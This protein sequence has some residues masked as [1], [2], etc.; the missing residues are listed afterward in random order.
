V[1]NIV[2]RRMLM[3]PDAKLTFLGCTDGVTDEKNVPE[4]ARKRAETVRDYLRDTW[5]IADNRL[6]IDYRGMPEKYSNP[7]TQDGILEN[8]RVEVLTDDPDI[9]EPIL[10]TDT[11]RT[12]YVPNVR[13]LPTVKAEAGVASWNVHTENQAKPLKEFKGTTT[14][15][16]N[17]DWELQK[18][19]KNVL[20]T[21][22]S[23]KYELTATDQ[24]SQQASTAPDSV[25]VEQLTIEKKRE[26][27]IADTVF[28]RYN[29]IL[30]DFG[31][32]TLGRLN[33][34]IAEFVKGRLTPIDLVTVTGFADRIGKPEFNKQL[35]EARAH[36][37][38]IAIN[39][40]QAPQHGVGG[41]ELLYD[42]DLPEGRFYCRTVEIFV[43]SPQK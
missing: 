26:L 28:A 11:I 17:I 9:L 23:V 37:T 27:H 19:N 8:R 33:Q 10:T 12:V 34:K 41:S 35:S 18:M 42:N 25:P 22:T 31:K 20:K 13:F 36:S 1:L 2:G 38:A 32:S 30:F 3:H 29:L 4:L 6:K 39:R 40:P 7:S 21:L 24:I 43:A 14:V 5:G 16:V 15:P